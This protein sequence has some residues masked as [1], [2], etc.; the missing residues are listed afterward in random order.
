MFYQDD[1]EKR[2]GRARIL[3][4]VGCNLPIHTLQEPVIKY[5]IFVSKI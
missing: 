3:G 4:E 1:K 2:K 5:L